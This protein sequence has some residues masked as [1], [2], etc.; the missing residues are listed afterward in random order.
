VVNRK[1]ALFRQLI[2]NIDK[3]L[4][5]RLIPEVIKFQQKARG[6]A[7]KMKMLNYYAYADT[8]GK[9]FIPFTGFIIKWENL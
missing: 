4:P 3:R 5:L 9:N 1:T 8:I 2:L 7:H 6:K